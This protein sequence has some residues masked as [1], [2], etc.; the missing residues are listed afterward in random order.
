MSRYGVSVG[1][2]P[3]WRPGCCQHEEWQHNPFIC[4]TQ[5]T[6]NSLSPWAQYVWSGLHWLSS[7]VTSFARGLNDVPKIAA[8]LVLTLSQTAGLRSGA[9]AQGHVFWPILLV[10]GVMGLGALWGGMRV[11]NVLAHQVTPLDTSSGLVANAGTSMLVLVAS[12]FGLPVS[13]THVSQAP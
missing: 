3:D 2:A 11:L 1:Q 13:T 9:I 12:P 5:A 10:T 7:G 6:R 8:F 4:A